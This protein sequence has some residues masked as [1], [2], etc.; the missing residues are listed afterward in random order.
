[1]IELPSKFT[2]V[3]VMFCNSQLDIH[4]SCESVFSV[5]NLIME[6]GKDVP[7]IYD[8]SK[9]S[10][11]LMVHAHS[12]D[13][14]KWCAVICAK[15]MTTY[16]MKEVE[17]KDH[18]QFVLS[19]LK[20]PKSGTRQAL[21]AFLKKLIK[22]MNSTRLNT[23]CELILVHLGA[24]IANEAE[25]PIQKKLRK[26]AATL[27]CAVSNAKLLSFWNLMIRWA[28]SAGNQVR[29]G[30]LLLSVAIT[31]CPEAMANLID[32]LHQIV[33]T[34]IASESV[35]VKLAA[36]DL[37]RNMI[38]AFSITSDYLLPVSTILD[39]LKNKETTRLGCE[40][41]DWYL[42]SF[43]FFDPDVP[44]LIDLANV[45][46]NVM[47]NWMSIIKEGS[48]SLHCIL[49]RIPL[50]ECSAFFGRSLPR[51]LEIESPETVLTM[52]RV[53]VA[54]VRDREDAIGLDLNAVLR[55]VFFL[56]KRDQA[57]CQAVERAIEILRERLNP[58][59]FGLVWE[60]IVKEDQ[61]RM[62]NKK[63]A[64]E[65]EWELDPEEAKR[66]IREERSKKKTEERK[67]R[68]L[69]PGDGRGILHPFGPDGKRVEGLPLAPEFR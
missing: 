65:I 35:K 33:V 6:K 9:R 62:K 29:T 63:M 30:L 25:E 18:L 10:F 53:T 7:E 67:K 34:H 49:K 22:S 38:S 32:S 42:N 23:Y 51:F 64:Q 13:V 16:E 37:H 8:L 28:S 60:E 59:Q 45:L 52:L 50:E 47:I 1:M 17:F 68:Y 12:G 5:I 55:F 20:S 61:E 44:I 58:Y 56:Q 4:D 3:L 69:S 54:T 24:Q 57:M 26:V 39:F 48:S 15:F 66:K 41:L 27:M 46:V 43:H 31:C 19:N 36:V 2:A 40:I 11:E 14:R 21:L